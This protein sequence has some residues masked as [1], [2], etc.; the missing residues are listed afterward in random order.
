[1]GLE[2]SVRWKTVLSKSKEGLKAGERE[3]VW[4]RSGFTRSKLQRAS[5]EAL[6][7]LIAFNPYLTFYV[8][9]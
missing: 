4:L 2:A 9:N 6:T 5:T 7:L 3:E 1:M 8:V